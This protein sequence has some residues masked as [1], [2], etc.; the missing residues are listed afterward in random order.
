MLSLNAKRQFWLADVNL[1][2][3]VYGGG[4]ASSGGGEAEAAS[5]E[6]AAAAH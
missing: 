3:A 6:D 1:G 5:A 4:S 2:T